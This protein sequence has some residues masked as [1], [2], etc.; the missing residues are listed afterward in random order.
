MANVS[1]ETDAADE[2]MSPEDEARWF[3]ARTL[4]DLGELTAQW[5]EGVITSHPGDSGRPDPE[6]GDLIPVLA[7]CNRAGF[8]T[9]DSQPGE[10]GDAY[11]PQRAA[12]TGYASTETLARLCRHLAGTGLALVVH[13]PVRQVTSD[14][15]VIVITA[16]D[17][18]YYTRCGGPISAEDLR[19]E[20]GEDLNPDA[21]GAL[22]SAWQV[23]IVDLEWGRND[24]LWPA[25]E[26][27]AAAQPAAGSA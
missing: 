20:Y 2:E 13:A 14:D 1:D 15:G 17:D 22:S 12:V 23:S 25:L 10:P 16:S 4:A 24:V 8:V 3:G 7:A 27:F 6:T 9:N 5:L 19:R 26:R 18:E 11:E 21:I